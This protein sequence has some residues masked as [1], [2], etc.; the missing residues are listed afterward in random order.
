MLSLYEEFGTLQLYNY[1]LFSHLCSR[2]ML[3]LNLKPY[4]STNIVVLMFFVILK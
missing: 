4:S 1:A 3:L 2:L